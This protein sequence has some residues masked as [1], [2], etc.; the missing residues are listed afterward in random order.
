MTNYSH[1]YGPKFHVDIGDGLKPISFYVGDGKMFKTEKDLEIYINRK[2]EELNKA[3][4][5]YFNMAFRY[6]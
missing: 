3:F 6:N 2:R 4:D 1:S 5:K